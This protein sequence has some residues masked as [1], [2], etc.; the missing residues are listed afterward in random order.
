VFGLAAP[1]AALPAGLQ[2]WPLTLSEDQQTLTYTITAEE[3]ER[4]GV[5]PLIKALEAAGVDL[6]TLDTHRSSLED[7][8]VDLVERRA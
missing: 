8:F 4:R 7:I 1:L 5:V 3:A 2:D 6:K